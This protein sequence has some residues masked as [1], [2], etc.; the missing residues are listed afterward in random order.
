MADEVSANTKGTIRDIELTLVDAFGKDGDGGRFGVLEEK[1]KTH[2]LIL[3]DLR[4]FKWKLIGIVIGMTTLGGAL[5]G[6]AA[7]ALRALH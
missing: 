1:V 6:F 3:D 4:S 2:G 7:L 5:A